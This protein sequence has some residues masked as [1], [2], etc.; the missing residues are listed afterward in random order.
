[1]K[2]WV[3]CL[4]ALGGPTLIAQTNDGIVDF[5]G[6]AVCPHAVWGGPWKSTI[7]LGGLNER[8]TFTLRFYDSRANPLRVPITTSSG[9]SGTVSE[10]AV[11][12]LSG[13]IESVE[14]AGPTD[15]E[16][17]SG[18]LTVSTPARVKGQVYE[19][20]R[21]TLPGQQGVEA[22]V[23]CA[24]PGG[25]GIPRSFVFDN[26]DG[27]ETG[28]AIVYPPN[29]TT[30]LTMNDGTAAEV[31]C[32]VN[33]VEIARF[34]GPEGAQKYAT[35]ALSSRVPLTAGRMGICR[36]F[37]FYTFDTVGP[38]VVALRFPPGGGFSTAPVGIR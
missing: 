34:R 1:M 36:V 11:P 33:G 37:N 20:F 15:G 5:P 8:A 14:L 24:L 27:A 7:Y 16:T 26:R 3:L 32:S 22:F 2:T 9:L 6:T 12:V 4:I 10:V 13:G 18:W 25:F 29:L 19:V 38:S 28:F 23:S 30:G 35:Y 31:G 21:Q 17:A